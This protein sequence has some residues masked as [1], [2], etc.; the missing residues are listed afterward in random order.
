MAKLGTSQNGWPV[1]STTDNFVRFTVEGRG[2]WAAN[3]DVAVVLKDFI[4][5]Y[6]KNIESINLKVKET[7]GY[8]DWSYAVRPVKGKT[9][10]YSNHGS[11]T[12]I[13]INATLHPFGVKNTFTSAQRT[14]LKAKIATYDGVLRHGEFYTSKVDGM[15][16]EINANAAAVKRMAAKITAAAKPQTPVKPV[17]PEVD[18]MQWNDLVELT[19]TDA[20]I[21]GGKVKDKRGIGTMIRYPP[22]VERVR[23]EQ[24][25]QYAALSKQ[26]VGLTA[27]LNAL[28]V[29]V[30]GLVKGSAADVQKAFTT[31]IANLKEELAT[32]DIKVSL[33]DTADE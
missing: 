28:N 3:A 10:G 19:A 17:V 11:A 6:H 26:I 30:G 1:Y 15:H 23:K 25:E 22:G 20:G 2:F 7:P 31:G 24:A 18:E 8:D 27:A 29:A 9:T 21:L 5:W 16:V 4:V 14:K 32:I 12:A 13:D 33:G